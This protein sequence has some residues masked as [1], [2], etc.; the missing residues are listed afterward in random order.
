MWQIKKGFTL[1]ELIVVMAIIG[2]MAATMMAINVSGNLAKGRDGQRK[3]H[4]EA[5]RSALEIYR[6]DL[7]A[8]PAGT[9]SLS[10]TYIG[11]VPVDPK[12][13]AAYAYTPAGTTY[14]LCANLEN[15]AG[16]YCVSNP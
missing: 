16:A 6:S 8:Y 7:G 4:L 13:A 12:T 10:P 3:A 11:T 5:I 9:G 1:I 15:P 2:V 14:T